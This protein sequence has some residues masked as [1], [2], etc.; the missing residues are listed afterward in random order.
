[1]PKV[2]D[3]PSYIAAAPKPAQPMLKQLRAMVLAVAPQ[4]EEKISYQ[5]P[6]YG[7]FGRLVYFAAFRDHVSLFIW[8]PVVERHAKQL[9]KYK[10]SKGTL[11]FPFGEKLPLV[12]LKKLVKGRM[13]ENAQRAT[14]GGSP[15]RISNMK[16]KK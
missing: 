14:S 6:Y 8:G 2:K 5:M 9:L 4:A 7:Y 3:V 16:K 1:M 15:V 13:V 10:T 11:Q 12:L